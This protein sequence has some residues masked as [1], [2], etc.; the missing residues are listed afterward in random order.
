VYLLG[1]RRQKMLTRVPRIKSAI[2]SAL[3][4]KI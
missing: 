3:W 1:V 2:E 4:L